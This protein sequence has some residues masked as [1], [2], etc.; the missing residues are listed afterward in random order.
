MDRIE[1]INDMYYFAKIVDH[2]GFTSAARALG[3]PTSSLSRRV[4]A[5]ESQLGVRLLNR[6]TRSISVSEAGQTFYRHCVAVVA[7]AFAA[8]E[9]MD[10]TRAE[11]HGLVRLSCPIQLLQ[12]DVAVVVAR[13]MRDHPLVRVSIDA[14]NRSV[15]VVDEGFDLAL[16]VRIPPLADSDLVVR[17][18]VEAELVLVGSPWLFA[19]HERPTT[20]DAVTRLPTLSWPTA[21]IAR[22]GSSSSRTA[23][24][25]ACRTCRGCSPTT[26]RRCITRRA[27]DSGSPTCRA[28]RS[29]PTWRLG[30][31]SRCCPT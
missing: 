27:R 9:A 17:V 2:G 22:S 6:T 8:K 21:A 30:G 4:T 11:P 3:V 18:L 26:C 14:T 29:R 24:C 16:R 12:V 19:Q 1:D 31:S 23:R 20:L 25:C 15:N 7:E 13:Y 10:Q 5:L 28:P